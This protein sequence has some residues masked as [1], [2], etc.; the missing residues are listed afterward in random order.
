L[1][2]ATVSSHLRKGSW[3][4]GYRFTY[5]KL[6]ESEIPVLSLNEIEAV[7]ESRKRQ[8]LK[9]I[10]KNTSL[11]T[12]YDCLT[13]EVTNYKTFDEVADKL[14]SVKPL[15]LQFT[16]EMV[17]ARVHRSNLEK[18]PILIKGFQI[19]S[20]SVGLDWINYSK[21]EIIASRYVDD[22]RARTYEVFDNLT[23]NKFYVT[24]DRRLG[25]YF[26][27]TSDRRIIRA[28]VDNGTLQ[29]AV[30]EKTNNRY[31]VNVIK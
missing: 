27:I 23:K 2:G 15:E 12:L 3:V 14:N 7:K 22:K 10:F 19:A 8:I 31:V 20:Q 5:E 21:G 24:G 11:I 28:K 26:N 9:P 29:Q 30:S 6:P 16:R 17:Q 1:A 25:V 18:S 4:F 13:T